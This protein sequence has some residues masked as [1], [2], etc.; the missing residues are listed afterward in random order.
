ML[1]FAEAVA[2]LDCCCCC[3]RDSADVL[4]DRDVTSFVGVVDT[5]VTFDAISSTTSPSFSSSSSSLTS[6]LVSDFEVSVF[7]E[8]SGLDGDSTIE[9]CFLL[10]KEYS[11]L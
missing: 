5:I 6:L 7:G 2:V 11:T 3:C 10:K 8:L 1:S 4:F 9:S